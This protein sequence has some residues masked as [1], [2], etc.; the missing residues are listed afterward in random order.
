MRNAHEEAH[1]NGKNN[2]L[3]AGF[4]VPLFEGAADLT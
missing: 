2:E 3:H 1:Y 4:A